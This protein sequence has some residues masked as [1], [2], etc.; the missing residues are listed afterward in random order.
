MHRADHDRLRN[1]LR[2]QRRYGG[3][4]TRYPL[5]LR[6]QVARHARERLAAGERLAPIAAS[7]DLALASLQRW[8]AA[9][10]SERIRPVVVD[11]ASDLRSHTSTAVLVTP[12]GIRV[13][14]LD[15]AQ[16]ATLLNVLS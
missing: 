14:G 15:V 5:S 3:L 6:Q 2:R 12:S 4:R 8:V 1:A 13:E 16:L 11:V 10:S 7:L 9:E